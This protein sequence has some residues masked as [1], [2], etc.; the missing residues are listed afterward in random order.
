MSREQAFLAESAAYIPSPDDNP[1]NEGFYRTYSALRKV[2]GPDFP[3]HAIHQSAG[4]AMHQP[5]ERRY[6][7]ALATIRGMVER[8]ESPLEPRPYYGCT[9][10]PQEPDEISIENYVRREFK[11]AFPNKRWGTKFAKAKLEAVR[12]QATMIL[13]E[14]YRKQVATYQAEQTRLDA[15]NKRKRQEWLDALHDTALFEN[16]VRRVQS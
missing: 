7:I 4:W 2:W 12:D 15:E 13:W 16:H 9:T 14:D 10:V 11:R 1:E 3:E 6:Q 8:V 5:L